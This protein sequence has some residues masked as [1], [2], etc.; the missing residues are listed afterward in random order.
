MAGS[1][2]PSPDPRRSTAEL[3]GEGAVWGCGLRRGAWCRV[4]G[5]TRCGAAEKARRGAALGE[6]PR[7]E[8]V[9]GRVSAPFY[10][11]WAQRRPSDH[12]S[13]VRITWAEHSNGLILRFRPITVLCYFYF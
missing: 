3:W 4:V 13:R 1:M 7:C 9:G 8:A 5:K 2:P 10:V 11:S 6:G 12:E